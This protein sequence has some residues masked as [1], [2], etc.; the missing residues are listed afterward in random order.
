MSEGEVTVTLTIP[1]AEAL[2]PWKGEDKS[3]GEWNRRADNCEDAQRA[4]RAALREVS[5][6]QP[7]GQESLLGEAA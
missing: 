1:Q 7:K 3:P 5:A 2:L 6:E 4:I